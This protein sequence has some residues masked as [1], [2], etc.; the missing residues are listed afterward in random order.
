MVQQHPIIEVDCTLDHLE[1]GDVLAALGGTDEQGGQGGAEREAHVAYLA[2][3]CVKV[4][5]P[6]GAY[7]IFNPAICTLPPAYTEPAIKLVGTMMVLKGQA[8]YE[9]MRRATHCTLLAVTLGSQAEQEALC[10]RLCYTEA[11]KAI[12]DACLAAMIERAADRVM[13]D[14]IR[15]ALEKGLYTDE[16]LSPGDADFPLEVRDGISF[17]LQAEKR[18]GLG[19]GPG[20]EP[21]PSY[22]AFSAVGMYDKSHAGRRRGCGRCKYRDFCSIRAI[23][24]NCHGGKGSFKQADA[25]PAV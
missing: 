13:A 19:L 2:D 7:K 17:Y 20:H 12:L 6:R 11:D 24:M 10:Q 5:K 22:A 16:R 8:I 14:I 23:G 1:Y 21:Q 18:L 4:L 25:P 3:E 15:M 9:R